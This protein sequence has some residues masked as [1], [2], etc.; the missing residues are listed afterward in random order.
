MIE[1][2]DTN[3]HLTY[4]NI[5][6]IFTANSSE[7]P[8]LGMCRL[9]ALQAADEEPGAR[10]MTVPQPESQHLSHIQQNPRF[11]LEIYGNMESA[12]FQIQIRQKK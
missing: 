3:G 7:F 6:I 8:C 1:R 9:T 11:G 10:G 12:S 4:S 2:W 5:M